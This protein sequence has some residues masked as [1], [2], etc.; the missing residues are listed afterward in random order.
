MNALI[1]SAGLGTRLAPL[2][3]HT[4]KALVQLNGKPLLSYAL[5]KCAELG[6]T[7]AVV[8]VHHFGQQVIDYLGTQV[9]DGMKIIISD[10]RDML[11]DTGGGLIKALPL[12]EVDKPILLYNV[13]VV[14][15]V[16]LWD[17]K[18]DHYRNDSIATLMVNKRE[19][20]R[21]FLFNEEMELCGWEN[22]ATDERIVV[23]HEDN[24]SSWGF[25][26]IHFIEYDFVTKLGELRKFSITGGY[27]EI[28]KTEKVFGWSNWHGYWFDVGSPQKLQE[29]A[30]VVLADK[31]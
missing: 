29:A 22:R 5:E 3:D 17:L 27:L 18:R 2:T 16:S 12:F 8:N 30:E 21:F 28:A 24:L 9:Y 11:L 23:R 4:P 19:G 13:D 15:N 1:Y 25:C 7:T 20:N 6:V 14:T 31:K 10:E 26:G